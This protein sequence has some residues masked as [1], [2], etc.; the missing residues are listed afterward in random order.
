ML[1]NSAHLSYC[2]I[3]ITH[4]DWE[5]IIDDTILRGLVTLANY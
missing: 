1:I 2:V 5:L 3:A 4:Y